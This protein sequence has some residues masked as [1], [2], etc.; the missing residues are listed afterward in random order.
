M[1]YG[2]GAKRNWQRAPKQ[3]SDEHESATTKK[4]GNNKLEL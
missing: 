4:A 3:R 1:R 2:D